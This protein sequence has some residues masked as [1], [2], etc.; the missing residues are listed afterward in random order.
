MTLTST[1]NATKGT[2]ILGSTSGVVFDQVNNRIG[3]NTAAP[4]VP[5]DV[6]GVS[7]L[8]TIQGSAASGGDLQLNT[9][10][11]GTKGNIFFG[12]TA[13]T[14]Y[15]EANDRFGAGTATPNSTLSSGGSLS[16]TR[17]ASGAANMTS[18]SSTILAVDD[19]AA[20]RTVTLQTAD[21][22]AGRVY[23]IIDESNG[24]GSN[25]ITVGTE[26]SELINGSAT[27]AI[28]TNYG[29]LKVYSDGTNWFI[30][31]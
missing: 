3:V 29:Y 13:T 15:D 21:T 30:I 8:P 10:T 6:T 31:G 18:G 24:A 5:L 11:H 22:V 12:A 4:A 7:M 16:V 14:T 28:S 20:P 19:T 23:I 1:S 2:I 9:T 25:T 26:G 27:Q 17:T